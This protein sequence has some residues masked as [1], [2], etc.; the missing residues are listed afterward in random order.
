MAYAPMQ[1]VRKV[2]YRVCLP[3]LQSLFTMTR[4]DLRMPEHEKTCQAGMNNKQ[5]IY[6]YIQIRERNED[7]S[8][9]VVF[10]IVTS[11]N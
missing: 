1:V 4:P 11:M 2:T 9:V 5:K 3:V 8:F 7:H 6:I 10:N